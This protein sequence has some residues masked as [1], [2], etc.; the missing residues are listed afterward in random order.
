MQETAI[1]KQLCWGLI[2]NI[3][4][5]KYVLKCLLV[6][7]LQLTVIWYRCYRDGETTHTGPLNRC[8]LP[9]IFLVLFG[10]RVIDTKAVYPFKSG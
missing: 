1:L 9:P 7:T 10:L 4:L 2:G 8:V 5:T 6:I 3:F